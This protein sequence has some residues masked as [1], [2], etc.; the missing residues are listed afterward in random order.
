MTKGVDTVR[1]VMDRDGPHH[2]L[3]ACVAGKSA[4]GDYCVTIQCVASSESKAH[5]QLG[6][7]ISDVRSALT[8]LHAS[9]MTDGS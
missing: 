1:K 4:L 2:I 5:A 7:V 8:V 6:P 3:T 9:G